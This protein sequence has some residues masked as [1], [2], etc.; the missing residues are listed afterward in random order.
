[1]TPTTRLDRDAL[2]KILSRQL[3]VIGRDQALAIGV[4]HHALRHRLRPG[5]Q[6]MSLLP[7]VYVAAT[8]TPTIVQQQ[9]AAMLYAGQGSVIT[10][11]AALRYHRI[12][13]TSRELVDILIPASRKRRDSAFVRVHRTFRMPDRVSRLGP[14][15]YA[16]PARA[17]ADAVRDLTSLREV[18]AVVADAIQ[19]NRCKI[20]E[21]H[22]ELTAGPTV[23]SALFRAALSDVAEGIRS[24]AEGDLKDLLAGSG[25]PMPLFNPMV[26]AGDTFVAKPD[27]W[28]PEFGIAVEV[29]SHEWH[30]SPQDHTRTLERQSRMGKYGIVVLPFTPR[31]IRSQPAEVI[32]TIREALESAR[33]RPPLSLNTIPVAA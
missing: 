24:A 30:M 27:A 23:G 12:R 32:A 28:W 7:G 21:L 11:P 17:V 16:P 20:Q 4:T 31:Q 33:S 13:G 2:A 15:R 29:D 10:G 19:R 6:W 18:R 3:D 1:M 25:L 14:L 26:F 9:M 8:G 5:G 22:A